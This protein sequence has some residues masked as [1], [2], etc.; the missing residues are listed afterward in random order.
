MTVVRNRVMEA[1]KSRWWAIRVGLYHRK[2]NRRKYYGVHTQ[3]TKYCGIVMSIFQPFFDSLDKAL[4]LIKKEGL[5]DNISTEIGVSDLLSIYLAP[6]KISTKALE[7]INNILV[8]SFKRGSKR[9][10]NRQGDKISVKDVDTHAVNEITQ[11]QID[12]LKDWEQEIRVKVHDS[13]VKGV[14]AGKTPGEL[15]RDIMKQSRDITENRA[16]LI[17][18]T[19]I[20]KASSR[21]TLQGLKEAGVEYMIWITTRDNRVCPICREFDGKRYQV[22]GK[23]PMPVEDTHPNCRCVVVADL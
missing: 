10:M 9:V 18:R 13:I 17:A 1:R 22:S 7:D 2:I 11:S 19:E 4:T 14:Q 3:I 8:D 5:Q 23:H 12:Y 15:K 16:L 20:T 6:V 21:G